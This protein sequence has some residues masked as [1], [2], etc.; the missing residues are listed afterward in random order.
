MTQNKNDIW[1]GRQNEKYVKTINIFDKIEERKGS[2]DFVNSLRSDDFPGLTTIIHGLVNVCKKHGE[3]KL[4]MV[5]M[6]FPTSI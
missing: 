5:V 3:F 4:A 6:I 2:L 1:I